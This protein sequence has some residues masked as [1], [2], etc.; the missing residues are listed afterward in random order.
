MSTFG[1]R[2]RLWTCVLCQVQCLSIFISEAVK[3]SSLANDTD[4]QKSVKFTVLLWAMRV[5]L[6]RL[7][8]IV[9]LHETPLILFTH[10]LLH[11]PKMTL[12]CYQLTR[13]KLSFLKYMQ[14]YLLYWGNLFPTNSKVLFILK[15]VF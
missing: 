11:L 9:R 10:N 4:V 6:N 2:L 13:S 8:Y 12:R 14:F 3:L 1:P 15:D 7:C 5:T